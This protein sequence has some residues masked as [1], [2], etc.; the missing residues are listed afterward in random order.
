[1]F[2]KKEWKLGEGRRLAAKAEAD[3]LL[4]VG[5]IGEA[6]YTTWLVNIVLVKKPTGKY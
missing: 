1:M 6:Q 4:K 5:F 3:K 2:G